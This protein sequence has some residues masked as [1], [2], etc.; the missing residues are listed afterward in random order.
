M[1]ALLSLLFILSA[2]SA[3][4]QNFT[5]KEFNSIGEFSLEQALKTKKVVINFWAEWCT[6]CIKELPELTLLQKKFG[7][8]FHFIAINAGDK[9][10]KIQKFLK[11]YEFNYKILQDPMKRFSKSIGVTSL[12]QT[13]VIDQDKTILYRNHIPPK[14]LREYK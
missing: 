10:R 1:K 8:D 14:N 3:Q 2:E 5:L 4:I 7:N 11:R 13:W 9:E 6:S 12:P